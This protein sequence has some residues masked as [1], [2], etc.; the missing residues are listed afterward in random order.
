MYLDHAEL[1]A[2]GDAAVG[3]EAEVE[4][5][6]LP[7]LVHDAEHLQRQ[8]VLPVRRRHCRRR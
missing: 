6:L 2:R 5:L 4:P 3:I 7:Q 8:H 1:I